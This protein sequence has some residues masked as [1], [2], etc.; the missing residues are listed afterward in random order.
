MPAAACSSAVSSSANA[1]RRSAFLQ[2]PQPR[3]SN[4]HSASRIANL[5]P[6]R[7]LSLKAFG[8]RPPCKPHRRDQIAPERPQPSQYAILV[9]AGEPAVSDH[10]R[11]KDRGKS[12]SLGHD[13]SATIGSAT[14]NSCSPKFRQRISRLKM[15]VVTCWS[16]KRENVRLEASVRCDTAI[17]PESGVKPTC[18]DTSTDA[19]DFVFTRP[20]PIP[21]VAA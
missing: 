16:G 13:C 10:I 1:L 12:P 20:R 11:D 4:P 15:E 14:A 6:L 18:R 9:R 5:R 19:I 2:A 17:R 7:F 21:E 8:R 3:H